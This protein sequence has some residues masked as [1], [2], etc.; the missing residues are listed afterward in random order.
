MFD[1][2]NILFKM[3]RGNILEMLFDGLCT[4]FMMFIPNKSYFLLKSAKK[5]IKV[6]VY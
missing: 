5:N 2:K 1:L 3:V 4:V 6:Q